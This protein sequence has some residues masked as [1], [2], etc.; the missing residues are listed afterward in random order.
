MFEINDTPKQSLIGCWGKLLKMASRKIHPHF[1]KTKR[2]CS[3]FQ[4]SL[5]NYRQDFFKYWMLI[6]Y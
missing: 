2:I 4:I 5:M 6:E 1:I 3:L